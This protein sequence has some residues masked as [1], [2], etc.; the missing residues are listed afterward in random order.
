MLSRFEIE[1]RKQFEIELPFPMKY[2]PVNRNCSFCPLFDRFVHNLHLIKLSNISQMFYNSGSRQGHILTT[3][4]KSAHRHIVLTP[5]FR[6]G[7]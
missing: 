4:S 7:S 1:L 6:A 3:G 2:N 5:G